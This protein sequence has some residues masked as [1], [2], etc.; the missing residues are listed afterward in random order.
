MGLVESAREKDFK[1]TYSIL[2]KKTNLFRSVIMGMC[3][4]SMCCD[5]FIRFAKRKLADDDD[6][7][8]Y[9]IHVCV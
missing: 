7:T 3:D 6:N 8:V 1:P 5:I 2:M 4:S 9:I